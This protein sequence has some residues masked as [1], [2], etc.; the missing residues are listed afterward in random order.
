MA[1]EM[2]LTANSGQVPF[3]YESKTWGGHEVDV[4]PKY[5]GAL[6]LKYCLDDLSIVSGA[7]LEI[8]CGAGGMVKAIKSAKPKSKWSS[9]KPN[10]RLAISSASNSDHCRWAQE[11]VFDFIEHQ[12]DL[13][14]R[15]LLVAA[16]AFAAFGL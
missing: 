16:A 2:A 10:S 7:I 9:A 1:D 14:S 5:L 8:G 4:S 15:L 13:I 12:A 6:R 11:V 3:D